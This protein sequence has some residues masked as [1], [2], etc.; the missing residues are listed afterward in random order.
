[1]YGA[2]SLLVA[3]L[4]VA[5]PAGSVVADESTLSKAFVETAALE[6]SSEF[7]VEPGNEDY[8]FQILK[9]RPGDL[10]EMMGFSLAG[11]SIGKD[12]ID[13]TYANENS[14][15][16]VQVRLLSRDAP[17]P[18]CIGTAHFQLQTDTKLA[19]A[20]QVLV[21]LATLMADRDAR[22]VWRHPRSYA[23]TPSAVAEATSNPIATKATS[24]PMTDDPQPAYWAGAE[25][26][27]TR[28]ESGIKSLPSTLLMAAGWL[29][30]GNAPFNGCVL[31]VRA[32]EA[33]WLLMLLG[34]AWDACRGL[35]YGLRHGSLSHSIFLAFL[36][37]AALGL[38]WSMATWGPGEIVW[39]QGGF[40]VPPEFCGGVHGSSPGGLIQLV[41]RFVGRDFETSIAT[42]LVLGSLAPVLLVLLAK[43]IGLSPI[44]AA[45]SGI[46][47][48]AHPLMVRFSGEGN[49]QSYMLLLAIAA[50]LPL[51]QY[52]RYGLRRYLTLYAIAATLCFH[53]RPEGILLLPIASMMT[54]ASLYDQR[55]GGKKSGRRFREAVTAH[56]IV[57]AIWIP[58]FF[59]LI[60]SF[61][62]SYVPGITRVGFNDFLSKQQIWLNPEYTATA[63]IAL[64]VIGSVIGLLRRERMV[65][66]AMAAL[67]VIAWPV[68]SLS[69]VDQ[70]LAIA[71][72]HTLTMPFAA[73]LA[74]YGLDR[75][76][77][78][79]KWLLS[80]W[81]WTVAWPALSATIALLAVAI[82]TIDPM[83]EI[84][85]PRTIDHEFQFLLRV[86]P[87]LPD[88]AEIYYTYRS[89]RLNIDLAFSAP[90]QYLS[91]AV[92]RPGQRWFPWE[93]D[94]TLPPSDH[95][96][97][98]YQQG[99]C[100]AGQFFADEILSAQI[101]REGPLRC[102]SA[103]ARYGGSP[104]F[105]ERIPA[106]R[107]QTEVYF[108][109]PM[110]IGIYR[111]P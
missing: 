83:R 82:T 67:A 20:R 27:S 7:I 2:R 30:V 90:T 69:A 105:T 53:T 80:F 16:K 64:L 98:Y 54:M 87:Q 52:H 44:A 61:W 92:G 31:L 84:T 59:V 62:S 22:N 111:M 33:L 56:A 28:L 104:V 106:V 57:G 94:Q 50:L 32:M 34:W 35:R 76:T 12:R 13:A 73:I 39:N 15:N 72:Y 5:C 109:D 17:C 78:V 81:K 60:R 10:L 11:M 41:S 24:N 97:F 40:F 19:G 63:T 29:V 45:A 47:I 6:S 101:A 3:I 4:L 86:L 102:M 46:L 71:R 49:R 70:N 8:L 26:I 18:G 23:P 58:Y 103:M 43:T 48:A 77:R 51:A 75:L 79:G 65:L 95:P 88:D 25:A 107:F 14:S 68:R 110:T 100:Y 42:Q 99:N 1:M 55:A 9:P 91:A 74:G 85:Y 36:F 37:S 96:R 66:W 108:M 38:R 89:P 21:A 93:S